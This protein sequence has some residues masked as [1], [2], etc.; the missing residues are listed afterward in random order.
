MSVEVIGFVGRPGCGKSTLAE[1]LLDEYGYIEINLPAKLREVVAVAFDWDVGRLNDLEY[2]EAHDKRWARANGDYLVRREAMIELSQALRRCD[3]N[4]LTKHAE[5]EI[6]DCCA[7]GHDLFVLPEIRSA[8]D[9]ALVRALG[10]EFWKIEKIGGP[11][12]ATDLDELPGDLIPDNI[13]RARHGHARDLFDQADIILENPPSRSGV[14]RSPADGDC[15]VVQ[16]G[17]ECEHHSIDCAT[18]EAW[19]RAS[20][21]S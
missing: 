2:K 15:G 21:N 7:L 11:H 12:G 19:D 18:P 13:L 3:P 8:A 16:V 5:R 9:V 4:F 6:N 20:K 17:G 14:V 1:Y 10:G